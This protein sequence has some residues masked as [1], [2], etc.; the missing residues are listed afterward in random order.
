MP[1]ATDAIAEALLIELS[2]LQREALAYDYSAL[3]LS[4]N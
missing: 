4:F 2:R 1:H 3:E